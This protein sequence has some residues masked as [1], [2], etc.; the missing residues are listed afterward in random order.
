MKATVKTNLLLKALKIVSAA[1]P[2]QTTLPI[3]NNVRIEALEQGVLCLSTT[4]LEQY[5]RCEIEAEVKESGE[6]ALP[7]RLFSSIVET[8]P[9][10]E[11]VLSGEI[12]EDAQDTI[13]VASP[14]EVEI[15][16]GDRCATLKAADVNEFPIYDPDLGGEAVKG[17][18]SPAVLAGLIRGTAYA[19]ATDESRPTLTGVYVEITAETEIVS[20]GAADGFRAA[21][22]QEKVDDL[23]LSGSCLIRAGHLIALAK[24]LG[25]E[26]H[27]VE[28][29][30]GSTRAMFSLA[31]GA[32]EHE[33]VLGIEVIMQLV[34][35]KHIDLEKIVPRCDCHVTYDRRE[36]LSA[37]KAAKAIAQLAADQVT[38]RVTEERTWLSAQ[39]VDTGD[40]SIPVSCQV[41]GEIPD[42][43]VLALNVA[44]VIDALAGVQGPEVV[45]GFASS[46]RPA[47]F[48][49]ESRENYKA[50][51]MPMAVR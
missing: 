30:I 26:A 42:P 34:E 11:L 18:L 33:G 3:L 38:F 50:I 14:V 24:Y 36:L 37:C 35:G 28:V 29:K 13:R 51:I 9:S 46:A 1:V 12:P 8:Y 40:T 17:Y 27:P 16:Q 49:P 43:N 21:M 7:F 4:D 45:L 25:E 44:F 31:G 22:M 41:S 6:T 48:L 15:S 5:I 47:L 2:R 32:G 19:A 39:A 10:G 23:D 20:F